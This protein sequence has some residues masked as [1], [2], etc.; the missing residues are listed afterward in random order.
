MNTFTW[1]FLGFLVLSVG[2]RL[3]L[4]QRQIRHVAAHR[5]HVPDAFRDNISAEAHRKAADY[6]VAK[7]QL[8]YWDLMLSTLLLLAWTLGGAFDWIDGLWAGAGWTPVW[9]GTAVLVSIVLINGIIELPLSVYSTFGVEQ[10]FG[11]NRTTPGT[12]I[13]DLFKGLAVGL[14]L[15]VPLVAAAL[16]FMHATGNWWWLWV[17]ALWMGVSLLLTWAYPTLIAP[18]FNRFSPLEDEVLKTRIEA[19]LD[20]CGFRSKGIFVMDGSKRSAHG[21]AYFTG[22]GSS[23]RIVFFDTLMETLDAAQIEAVLAHELGHFK[24][25]HI[26]KRLLLSAALSLAG[27]ALLGWLAN[28]GWFYAG[29]GV[30]R[31]SPH[32]ALLLFML[33]APAFTFL[34][35]PLAA[36]Y[37]RK[38]EFEADA[39]ATRQS[40]ATALVQA[41]VNL[42]RENASTL[43]PDPLHSAFYDSHP[44]APVRIQRLRS[45]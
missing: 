31:Q 2:L 11:F 29:L 20:R 25:K 22:I 17:W 9:T 15:G 18:L 33:A 38:H 37:S 1:I 26:T 40:D 35:T 10:R 32:A 39:Y 45:A 6:T 27:L 13:G 42:Y 7:V 41:L 36:A 19:L 44:P 43:T 8:G 21:N 4:A 5:G 3:W 12:Y 30:S 14:A 16:W 28:Q 23:K 34:L 24:L